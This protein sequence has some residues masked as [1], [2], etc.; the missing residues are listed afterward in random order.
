MT[1]A[2]VVNDVMNDTLTDMFM[3][4]ADMN[5]TNDN[6]FDDV[7]DDMTS[8]VNMQVLT[9]INEVQLAES[10]VPMIFIEMH[11]QQFMVQFELVQRQV[12]AAA[13]FK[14][15]YR[16]N[17]SMLDHF[18][19]M[20]EFMTNLEYMVCR[21]RDQL[22]AWRESDFEGD[23]HTF[24]VNCK[25]LDN[26]GAM[27]YVTERFVEM[28][29]KH[30]AKA[31][32]AEGEERRVPFIKGNKVKPSGM[33]QEAFEFT[34]ATQF[35]YHQDMLRV[36]EAVKAETPKLAVW[37]NSESVIA[38]CNEMDS[39]QPYTTEIDGDS[40][41]RMYNVAHY[42]PNAQKDDL[43]RSLYSLA[44]GSFVVKDSDV[45]KFLMV[46]LADACGKS[47]NLMT[48]KS[49]TYVGRNPVKSLIKLLTEY[50]LPSPFM[51]IRLAMELS[52]VI[53]NG[54]GMIHVPVGLDAKCSGTQ[55]YS[56]IAGNETLM[57]ATG[58]CSINDKTPDPYTMAA[59]AFGG[60]LTRNAMKKPYMVVQYGGGEKALNNDKEFMQLLGD[61]TCKEV[62][63]AVEAVLGD[64]ICNLRDMI[65]SKVLEICNEK[66]V[67]YFTYTHIDGFVVNKPVCGKVDITDNYSHI[68]YAQTKGVISFGSAIKGTG[69]VSIKDRKHNREEFARTF[70]VN[71]IQGIDGLIAR[72]VAVLAKR[73]GIR[74]YV[75]IHD[76]FR[77]AAEDVLKLKN[78]INEAYKIVFLDN[79]P[80]NHL[81]NQLGIDIEAEGYKTILTEEMIYQEDNYYFCQ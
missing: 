29:I 70:M 34:G 22:K 39:E 12:V 43:N 32:L 8:E 3:E 30:T 67:E 16:M 57:K 53:N 64:K 81:C 38:G 78:I 18:D 24:L 10:A 73:D 26:I 71:Y 21:N 63:K 42:G 28:C 15:L 35:S 68:R 79:S 50:D 47:D 61:S 2:N 20:N 44:F 59:Q 25:L 66:D 1:N 55:I 54:S 76:C 80:L 48:D 62:I 56:I 51:Y 41:G 65:A 9:R 74:G 72:T 13:I 40:R 37:K 14:T 7:F 52:K 4:N 17:D 69:L 5:N 46:E 33:M 75:S 45:Y 6:V 77:C 49:I 11:F 23:I 27:F 60:K 58:F 19:F 31:P 36:I